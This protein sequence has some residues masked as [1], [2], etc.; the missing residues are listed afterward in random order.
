MA[1]SAYLDEF[2][3]LARA[4]AQGI[5]SALA[6]GPADATTARLALERLG[7]MRRAGRGALPELAAWAE[8]APEHLLDEILEQ[9]EAE[10]RSWLLPVGP[11][12]LAEEAEHGVLAFAL[13]RRDETASLQS[14]LT[15]LMLPRG[16]SPVALTHWSALCATLRRVDA[17]L[18]A[19]VP[20]QLAEDLLGLRL[21]LSQS[22]DWRSQLQ[23]ALGPAHDET[24]LDGLELPADFGEP[25]DELVF[26]YLSTGAL[27]KYI[28]GYAAANPSFAQELA[29]AFDALQEEGELSNTLIPRRWRQNFA[30]RAQEPLVFPLGPLKLAAA[31][32]KAATIARFE[33]GTLPGLA[34]DVDALLELAG[35]VWSLRLEVGAGAL[36]RVALNEHVVTQAN[37]DESWSLSVQRSDGPLRLVVEDATGAV[38]E[39]TLRVEPTAS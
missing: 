18:A 19:T 33:L 37:A 22:G 35:G 5:L 36:T 31:D 6:E 1:T 2:C 23:P 4:A 24:S 7:D 32:A 34:A 20:R 39:T 38:F 8:Q 14:A 29:D 28:E 15:H 9:A 21:C 25:D 11:V 10:A 30:G 3:A 27:Y 16:R 26:D 17:Q 13:Q 12:S